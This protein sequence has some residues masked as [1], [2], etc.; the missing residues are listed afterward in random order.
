MDFPRSLF[1]SPGDQWVGGGSFAIEHIEDMTQYHAA[2]KAGWFDSVPEALAAW[3]ASLAAPVVADDAPPTRAEMEQR[4]KELGIKFD[5][6][7][8]DSA[9]LRK[10]SEA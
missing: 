5:G 3:K 1:K 10:I 4:A 9:L 6:R 2:K 7:T 8:T